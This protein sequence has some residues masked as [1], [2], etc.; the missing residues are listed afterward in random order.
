MQMPV[1]MQTQEEYEAVIDLRDLFF[2]I[3]YRWRVI[4]ILAL[5]AAAALAFWQNYKIDSVHA[6]GEKTEEEEQ[7]EIDL[8]TYRD[9]LVNAESTVAVKE[10]AIAHMEE[11]LA[12]SVW[13]NLD[14]GSEYQATRVYHITADPSEIAAIPQ[15]SQMDPADYAVNTYAATL[16]SGL[17]EEEL[18]DLFGTS[19]R[20]YVNE[21]VSVS[22][23]TASNDVTIRV[24]GGSREYVDK[25]MDF[26]AAKIAGESG[27]KAQE[28]CKHTVKVLTDDVVVN[29]NHQARQT[30]RTE[31]RDSIQKL[32]EDIAKA[33]AD[34]N[35][36]IRKKEPTP[37]GKH[38]LRYAVIG[39]VVGFL[40]PALFFAAM[41][42]LGGRI[43]TAEDVSGR[44]RVPVY[45]DLAHSRARRP[46]KGID[47]L[48]ENWEF[49]H[50]ERDEGRMYDA[51]AA[52]LREQNP[53]LPL[54]LT[55]TVGEEKM[56][57]AMMML[58]GRLPEEM[59][60]QMEPDFV[61]RPEAVSALGEAGSV[62][63]VEEKHESRR[64]EMRRMAEMLAISGAD[65]TGCVLL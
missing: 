42:L 50:K 54:V 4:V 52:L 37:P 63:L 36:L 64:A 43:H 7:F 24:I 5:V 10:K 8:I 59:G 9:N 51:V 46:G 35:S 55:G 41:Y 12:N 3:L 31:Y 20:E 65:V 15:G 6:R 26:F 56:R 60:I 18:L 29:E 62:L 61:H 53:T 16:M 40:L 17:S 44:F 1:P 19:R 14:K 45:G 21:L 48:I 11:Y 30:K 2:H 33:R 57:A 39:G 13:L 23:N 34:Y 58:S 25:I 38:I 49:R 22:G 32:Q 27:E 47:Q 28:L